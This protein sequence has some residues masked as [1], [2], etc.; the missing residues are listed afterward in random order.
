MSDISAAQVKEL[1][2][3]T[4]A[5]MMDCK[6]A[7]GE[8][9]GDMDV[10]IQWLRSKGL[11]A[12]AK[13]A[14]R[15]AAEGLVAVAVD[16][17]KGVLVEVNSETDFVARNDGFQELAANVAKIALELGGDHAAASSAPYPGGAGSVADKIT[18]MV[19]KIGENLQFRR[20]SG[21]RVKS[22]VIASYVHNAVAPGMGKI[23]VLVALESTGDANALAGLGKQLAMHVAAANPQ[24]VRVADLDPAVIAQEREVYGEQVRESGKP[25]DI[26]EK[27][28]E[29]RLRKFYGEAVLEEQVFVI[30]NETK[31]AK[32][33]E[34]AAEDAGAPVSITGFLRFSLGEGI[35][36]R[37]EDFAAEVAAVR[38]GD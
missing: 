34:D 15:I 8:S 31:I 37:E 5:G 6:K 29:G 24:S 21:L 25:D 3:R 12:A 18:E 19:S 28:V 30:D 9:G 13:K 35:E 26:V 14:G 11:S 32:V 36:K 38:S 7:L 2:E 27:I 17:T 23:G 1:R 16:G 4:G 33:V 20:S 10:A 22:G